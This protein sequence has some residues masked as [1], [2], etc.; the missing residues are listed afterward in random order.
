MKQSFFIIFILF[1]FSCGH[2][3]Q[4]ETPAKQENSGAIEIVKT[5]SRNSY[6]KD[7]IGEMSEALLNLK[8]EYRAIKEI[9]NGIEDTKNDSIRGF[10]NYKKK[11]VNYYASAKQYSNQI[12]DSLIRINLLHHIEKSEV[13]FSKRT[14]PANQV[15]KLIHENSQLMNDL[16]RVLIITSTIKQMESS[17][18]RE[19]DTRA[20]IALLKQQQNLLVKLNAEIAKNEYNVSKPNSS[21]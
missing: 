6:S 18:Q 2:K 14:A 16:Y 1:I 5:S 11:S 3:N 7:I 12:N 17:Q 15:V 19:L 13:A 8:P 4:P 10:E 9:L 21:D 20:I